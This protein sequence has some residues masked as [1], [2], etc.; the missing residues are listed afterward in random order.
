MPDY[1]NGKIY[2]IKY[3]LDD[4]L[5]Y[6][7]STI[8]TLNNRWYSHKCH[9]FKENSK[10]YNKILY[11]KIRETND[12]K[13]WYIELYL[14]FPCNSK[15]ELSRKEGEIQKIL[16]PCLN[17]EIAGRTPKEY[18]ETTKSNLRQ[19]K[20]KCDCGCYIS[21]VHLKRHIDSFKHKELLKNN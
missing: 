20:V 5:L 9:C 1:S 14:D 10:E 4:S 11:K 3:K 2:I 19:I 18:Y 7:G 15:K 12:F 21:R 13:N 8:Q 6:V 16:K 17:K